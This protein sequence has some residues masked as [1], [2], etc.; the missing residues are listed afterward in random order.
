MNRL[1]EIPIPIAGLALGV[2]G[3]GNILSNET[4]KYLFMWFHW[5]Y[6]NFN[7]SFKNNKISK[8]N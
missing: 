1:K 5:F 2:L 8:L 7:T 4:L 3:L 6:F